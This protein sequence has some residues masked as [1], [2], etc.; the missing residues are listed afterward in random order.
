MKTIYLLKGLPASGKST[1]AREKLAEGNIKRVNKDDLRAMIDNSKW[2]G[3]NEKFIKKVRD[4]IVVQALQTGNHVIVDDT[5]LH[6]GHYDRMKQLAKEN[7]ARVEVV[8]FDTPLE[9]CI[10]RDANRENSVGVDVI[11]GMY[12]RYINPSISHIPSE[13]IWII[14]DTHFTHQMLIDAGVRPADYN[15]QIAKNWNDLV[16]PEDTVVHL[17]DVIFGYEKERLEGILKGLNGTKVLVKGNHDYKPDAW[18]YKMGFSN[19]YPETLEWNNVIFSHI[20]LPKVPWDKVNIHGHLHANSGH[21]LEEVEHYLDEQ[22]HILVALELTG[23]K[24]L[25]FEEVYPDVR[26]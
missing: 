15:E 22:K 4:S 12:D 13:K 2:T 23:Y 20:P 10:E 14:S 11:Q 17:G 3:S 8:E 26:K 19:V 18:Y 24:P 6:V 5:N 16:S 25:R 21:R 1:W 7:N 9:V